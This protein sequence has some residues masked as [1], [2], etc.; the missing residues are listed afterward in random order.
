MCNTIFP[1]NF[2]FFLHASCEFFTYL[3]CGCRTIQIRDL[4]SFTFALATLVLC[5]SLRFC[6]L[7]GSKE[8]SCPNFLRVWLCWKVYLWFTFCAG[9]MVPDLVNVWGNGSSPH[10]PFVALQIVGNDFVPHPPR[11]FNE[12]LSGKNLPSTSLNI[13]WSSVKGLPALLLFDAKVEKL[14]ELFSFSLLGK[15]HLEGLR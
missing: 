15:F 3:N 11:S 14:A 2:F 13:V 6:F 8:V 1:C 10:D 7:V 12:A 9:L 5:L 4:I